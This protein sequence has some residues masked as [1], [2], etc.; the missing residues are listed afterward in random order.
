MCKLIT[1]AVA[2]RLDCKY[3]KSTLKI[4]SAKWINVR[5]DI[6]AD[7]E[8]R[9][10]SLSFSIQSGETS[11]CQ[12][13]TSNNHPIKNTEASRYRKPPAVSSDLLLW[14]RSSGEP[15]EI[16]IQEL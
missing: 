7:T 9:A 13:S 12:F 14:V 3:I 6:K 2:N 8:A 15:K 16:R 11:G 4:S 5:P 1:V 10:D